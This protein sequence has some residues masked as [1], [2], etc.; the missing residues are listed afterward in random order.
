MWVFTNF[1]FYSAAA[2]PDV[3]PAER[4]QIRTRRRVDLTRLRAYLPE[5]SAV[6]HTLD[7]DYEWRAY[8]TQEQWGQALAKMALEVNSDKFKPTIK[9]KKLAGFAMRVWSVLVGLT[10]AK[11]D[12]WAR[13]AGAYPHGRPAAQRRLVE[14]PWRD[15]EWAGLPGDEDPWDEFADQVNRPRPPRV[16]RT[17][18]AEDPKPKGRKL[19]KA[20]RASREQ[21]EAWVDRYVRRVTS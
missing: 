15:S 3:D 21:E 4:I 6:E 17:S 1:G 13:G 9:D 7:K 14:D 12:Y 2:V 18:L 19:K 5:L 20:K 16:R 11:H 8:C 10:D